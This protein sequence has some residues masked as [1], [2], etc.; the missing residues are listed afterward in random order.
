[1]LLVAC[2]G[3]KNLSNGPGLLITEVVSENTRG[4]EDDF[5][6]H[7][8]WIEITNYSARPVNLKNYGLSDNEGEPYKWTFPYTVI[9]AGESIIVYASNRDQRDAAKSLHT[10]FRISG[11]GEPVLLTSPA[12]NLVDRAPP[13]RLLPNISWGR[14]GTESGRG[15]W[16]FF[17][18]PTPLAPNDTPARKRL[19][20][21]GSHGLGINEVAVRPTDGFVDSDG[22]TA[23]WIE[24]VNAS[25]GSIDLDG[26]G[27]TDDLSDPFRWRFKERSVGAGDHIVV[28]AS[29]KNRNGLESHTNFR[30]QT[31]EYIGLFTPNGELVDLVNTDGGNDH[32]SVGRRDEKWV[33]FGVATPGRANDVSST[34][35]VRT[36]LPVKAI[37]INEVMS[38][39]RGNVLGMDWVELKN[40]SD[41]TVDLVGYGLSDDHKRPLRWRFPSLSLSAG[42][43]TVIGLTGQNCAPPDCRFVEADF[44]LSAFGETLTISRPDGKVEDRLQTGRHLAGISSGRSL[45]GRKSYFDAPTPGKPNN[46]KPLHGYTGQPSLV[47]EDLA[48]GQ[49]QLRIPETPTSGDVYYTIGGDPPSQKSRK[50]EEPLLLKKGMVVRARAYK[51]GFLPS[52]IMTRTFLGDV[53]HQMPVVAITVDPYQMFNKVQGLHER[54]LGASDEYPYKGANFWSNRELVGH[55]EFLDGDG[56][57]VLSN[58]TGVQIFGAWSRGIAKKSFKI[59]AR[60]EFG[61]SV[62]EYPV[63]GEDTDGWM[64]KIVLRSGGQDALDAVFRDALA[65]WLAEGTNV[66]LR[67]FSP[68]VLYINGQYWGVYNMRDPMG[69]KTLSHRR[70]VAPEN[71]RLAT[72]EG[73]YPSRQFA[74]VR[75]Y[76]STHSSKE[77]QAMAWIETR[78]DLTS[79]MDWLLLEMFLD[80]RDAG[81]CRYWTS[82]APNSKWRWIFYDLDLGMNYPNSDT[83]VRTLS[84]GAREVPHDVM[85]LYSWLIKSPAFKER[86]LERA[87]YMYKD[88][89]APAR[90]ERGI[91][92]FEK[93]YGSEMEREQERWK[94]IRGWDKSVGVLRR[95]F[96]LRPAM[97]RRQ[98][99]THFNLTEDETDRLFPVWK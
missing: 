95:F 97:M 72:G 31:G 82:D 6:T 20:S 88:I 94:H 61:A 43:M 98:F 58:G 36:D 68:A 62:F 74:G 41:E 85:V 22:E 23:D 53:S 34:Q 71:I 87:S 10:N 48:G 92:H 55:V 38:E 60:S 17:F 2:S 50:Y 16:R 15:Q 84:P 66:D 93:M 35:A 90:V 64:D 28:F 32:V 56:G 8:D 45:D 78:V 63:F 39:S 75:Q 26:Y 33:Q 5:H 47:V 9:S 77:P 3:P 67:R 89:F 37:T 49:H 70:G 52:P 81:N 69:V 25:G 57:L 18:Q 12:H 91:A 46:G 30:I 29:A 1:M 24:L 86:F 96:T 13:V 73:L 76:I 51:D 21:F 19:D 80:N 65:T 44:R 79:F 11:D 59:T 42:E 99:R 7:S 40:G 4:I 54:G 14:I 83:V 27:L